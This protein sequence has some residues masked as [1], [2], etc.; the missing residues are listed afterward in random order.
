[1][2]GTERLAA[3]DD[4]NRTLRRLRIDLRAEGEFDDAA[5]SY[6]LIGSHVGLDRLDG[7]NDLSLKMRVVKGR[8]SDPELLTL[9]PGSSNASVSRI[10][11]HAVPALLR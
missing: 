9:G 8:T 5:W 1:M 4:A 2:L 6:D 7:H 3:A 10:S 11:R